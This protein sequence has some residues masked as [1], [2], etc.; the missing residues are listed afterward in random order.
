MT[1]ESRSDDSGRVG[2]DNGHVS[3][4]HAEF[5]RRVLER[6]VLELEKEVA[7]LKRAAAGA[8]TAHAETAGVGDLSAEPPEG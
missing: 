7:D 1:D 3:A 5:M 8:A 6:R 2:P 4:K